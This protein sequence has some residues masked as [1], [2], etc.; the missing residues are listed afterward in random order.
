MPKETP[1]G[2]LSTAFGVA[3]DNIPIGVSFG[4]AIGVSIGV[5]M[6][7]SAKKKTKDQSEKGE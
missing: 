3:M 1:I 2:M 6:S 4:T 5:A 7:S